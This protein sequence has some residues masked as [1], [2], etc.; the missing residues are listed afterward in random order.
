MLRGVVAGE[1]VVILVQD[2]VSG[3]H[4]CGLRVHRQRNS[5]LPSP[6]SSDPAEGGRGLL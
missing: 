2:H 1:T 4:P 3:D 5:H 6:Q